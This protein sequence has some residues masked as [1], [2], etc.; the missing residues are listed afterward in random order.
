MQITELRVVSGGAGG[1]AALVSSCAGD[2]NLV[3]WDPSALPPIQDLK[4]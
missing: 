3:I 1:E 4:L 2:G